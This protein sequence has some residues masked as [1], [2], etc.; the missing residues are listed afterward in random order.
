MCNNTCDGCYWCTYWSE[1]DCYICSLTDG[2]IELHDEAC[3]EFLTA[4]GMLF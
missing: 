4:A 1:A 3:D 2:R